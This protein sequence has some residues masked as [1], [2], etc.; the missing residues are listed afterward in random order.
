MEHKQSQTEYMKFCSDKLCSRLNKTAKDMTH[1][2]P[3]FSEGIIYCQINLLEI[4]WD[5]QTFVEP[6]EA[7]TTAMISDAFPRMTVGFKWMS[8]MHFS[9]RNCVAPTP[10]GS[11]TQGFWSSFARVAAT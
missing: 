3:N 9:V 11:K 6:V 7:P 4:L 1:T 8:S 5:D 2:R 10:T